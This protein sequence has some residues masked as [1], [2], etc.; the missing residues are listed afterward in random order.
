MA[1]ECSPFRVFIFLSSKFIFVTMFCIDY[2]RVLR[3]DSVPRKLLAVRGRRP[4]HCLELVAEVLEGEPA[5]KEITENSQKGDN[6]L[7]DN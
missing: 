2:Y 7:T 4:G 1:S 6:Q 3:S 5:P